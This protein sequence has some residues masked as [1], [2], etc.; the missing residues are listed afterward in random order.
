MK[1]GQFVSCIFCVIVVTHR[2]AVSPENDQ[3]VVCMKVAR[4]NNVVASACVDY[5]C[6]TL[7]L[8]QG[9][10]SEMKLLSDPPERT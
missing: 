9:P 1:P 10:C 4:C 3:R 5:E 7:H 8:T 2:H 6:Q